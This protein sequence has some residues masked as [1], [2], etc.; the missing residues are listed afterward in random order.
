MVMY[1]NLNFTQNAWEYLWRHFHRGC[2]NRCMAKYFRC[3]A[4]YFLNYHT[5]IS[6]EINR[7]QND[8]QYISTTNKS[9]GLQLPGVCC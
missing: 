7:Q 6:T 9:T 4:L 2:D 8:N 3:Y 5:D 1:Q